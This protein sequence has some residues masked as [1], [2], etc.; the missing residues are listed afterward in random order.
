MCHLQQKNDAGILFW[1]SVGSIAR[2]NK[3]AAQAHEAVHVSFWLG[4]AYCIHADNHLFVRSYTDLFIGLVIKHLRVFCAQ[5]LLDF[6][7]L[8]IFLKILIFLLYGSIGNGSF[9]KNYLG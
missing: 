5:A 8:G 1:Q 3:G 7:F 4:Y 9:Q 6:S 2:S